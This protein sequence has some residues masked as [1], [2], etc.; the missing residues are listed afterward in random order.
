MNGSLILSLT[1]ELTIGFLG[2]ITVTYF[3]RKTQIN[4]I[5]PFDFISALVLGELVGNAIYDEKINIFYIL[6]AILLWTCLMYIV[7]LVTQKFK[8]TRNFLEGNPSILIRHGQIDFNQLKKEKL[9]INELQSLLRTK[10]VFSIREVEYAV[11]EPSGSVS[12]LKKSKYENPTNKDLNLQE[13]PVYLPV[14][15]ILD[16]EVLWDN[17][18]ASGFDEKWLNKQL[19][20]NNVNKIKDVLYAE[21]KKDEG[22]HIVQYKKEG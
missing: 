1:L 19:H 14:T 2:L 20:A 15:F 12:I 18:K 8:K 11:L 16:G 22:F 7:E 9:D 6:Y 21:W 17:L 10:D 4:Q 13:K 5:T 3:L